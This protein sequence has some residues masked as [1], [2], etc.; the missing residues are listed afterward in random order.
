ME[1]DEHGR[2]EEED[3]DGGG[4]DKGGEGR[5][6]MKVGVGVGWRRMNV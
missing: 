3:K 4:G 2:V 1:E 5:W 6:W